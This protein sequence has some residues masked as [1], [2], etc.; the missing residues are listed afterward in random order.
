MVRAVRSGPGSGRFIGRHMHMARQGSNP[1]SLDQPKDPVTGQLMFNC[2]PCKDAGKDGRSRLPVT[3][4]AP[5]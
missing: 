3:P 4:L 2:L 5:L 1:S